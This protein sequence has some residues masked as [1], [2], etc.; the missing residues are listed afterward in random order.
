MITRLDFKATT[1]KVATP[2]P[3]AFGRRL[4]CKL[5]KDRC[6]LTI[7]ECCSLITPK[8]K[9][10]AASQDKRAQESSAV[11]ACCG[12]QHSLSNEVLKSTNV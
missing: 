8:A 5:S 3:T 10:S 12:F 2:S 11:K 4:T 7:K 6:C 9:L 1:R